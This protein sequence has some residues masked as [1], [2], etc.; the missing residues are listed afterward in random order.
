[1]AVPLILAATHN[2]WAI[3]IAFFALSYFLG[4]ICWA[5]IDSDERLHA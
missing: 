4:A 2:S 3:N 1:M 5:F